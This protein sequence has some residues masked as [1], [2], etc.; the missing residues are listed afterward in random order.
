MLAKRAQAS[1]TKEIGIIELCGGSGLTESLR[2]RHGNREGGGLGRGPVRH[3]AMD[4]DDGKQSLIVSGLWGELQ[5]RVGGGRCGGGVLRCGGMRQQAEAEA[6]EEMSV[7]L[8]AGVAS[9]HEWR[10]PRPV[11]LESRTGLVGRRAEDSRGWSGLDGGYALRT[12]RWRAG[13]GY[14]LRT[15]RW[16]AGRGYALRT[17]QWRAGRGYALRIPPVAA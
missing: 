10:S 3:G 6:A 9:G 8:A 16:R 13:R 7:G 14:A 11:E 15:R 5:E 4:D 12:R 17:R 1:E 2:L